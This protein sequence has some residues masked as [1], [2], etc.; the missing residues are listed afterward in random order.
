MSCI[1][2]FMK[3]FGYN[4][5]L[6]TI[7]FE[8]LLLDDDSNNSTDIVNMMFSCRILYEECDIFVSKRRIKWSIL[9]KIYFQPEN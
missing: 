7:L 8:F 5:C 6:M 9:N 1:N 2:K 3:T 4:S